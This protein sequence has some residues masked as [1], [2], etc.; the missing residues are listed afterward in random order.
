[1]H[2]FIDE[3]GGF[4]CANQAVAPC[5][6]GSAT[7]PGRYYPE[8]EKRF[9][10][11]T[12][13]WPSD[14]GEI[15]GKRLSETHFRQLCEFLEP[16]DVLF[17]CSV[18]DMARVTEEEASHHRARQAEGMTKHL[19]SEHHPNLVAEVHRLRGILETMPLQLY[20]Q[21]VTL[22]HVVRRALEH[23][24]L[25]YCQRLPGELG[26]FRWVI[27][28][29][30]N[31]NVTPQEDWWRQC[32][33]P[34]LQSQS[35]REPFAMLKGGDY[36][37]YRRNFPSR[38]VPDY[39]RKHIPDNRLVNDLSAVLGR[40]MEFANSQQHVGLQIAD[41]LTNC[42]RRVLKGNLEAAGVT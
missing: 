12:A 6:V 34:M 24:M 23:S 41:A 5:C 15:K 16:Y 37:A 10:Q 32:V 21:I 29:K 1:M 11:L 26:R 3:S 18:M 28:A 35:L 30:S 8:V 25:Y 4:Q 17:E 27:D 31:L 9:R 38:G 20:A 40:G 22:T 19:S 33:K 39:L 7:I 14:N 13:D 2:I 36:S 42:V